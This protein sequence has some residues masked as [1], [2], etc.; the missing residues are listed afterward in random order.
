MPP[1]K[2]KEEKTSVSGLL[3]NLRKEV[4]IGT[5]S[6]VSHSSGAFSTGNVAVDFRTGIGGYPKGRIVEQYGPKSSGKTTLALQ[7][8][9]EAQK[10]IIASGETAYV[11]FFDYEKTFD[12]K[13]AKNLGLDPD[14]ESFIYLMPN[15]FEEG[16][17]IYREL[18]ATGEVYLAVF[19]SVAAMITE[20]EIDLGVQ[21]IAK[22][23]KELKA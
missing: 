15:T 17:N 10:E 11:M 22:A 13:Y 23:I 21:A 14:H 8:L 4:Q 12:G 6:E 20:K 1:A 5:L 3:A 18:L 2:K 9:A 16:A 7:A 19:D